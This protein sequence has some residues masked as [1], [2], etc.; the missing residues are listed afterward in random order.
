MK[1][2]LRRF[3]AE[4]IAKYRRP[5]PVP[6][7]V[8]R[9]SLSSRGRA[10]MMSK[11]THATTQKAPGAIP[12]PPHTAGVSATQHSSFSAPAT[13]NPPAF[14]NPFAP[15]NTGSTHTFTAPTPDYTMGAAAPLPIAYT[16]IRP[17][18]HTE[19]HGLTKEFMMDNL[20][21]TLFSRASAN[22]ISAKVWVVEYD[23][24]YQTS[25][26]DTVMKLKS[27][28][29]ALIGEQIPSL[30]II[31]PVAVT[32]PPNRT[33]SR[34][35]GFLV[36]GLTKRAAQEITSENAGIWATE[37][38][39]FLAVP[40][41]PEIT[42]FALTLDRFTLLPNQYRIVQE[43]IADTLI[44]NLNVFSFVESNHDAFPLMDVNTVYEQILQ[45]IEAEPVSLSASPSGKGGKARVVWN[46]LITS[47]TQISSRHAQWIQLL[48]SLKYMHRLGT[49]GLGVPIQSPLSCNRCKI[50]GHVATACPL[51]LLPDWLGPPPITPGQS[52]STTAGPS[53]SG[54]HNNGSGGNYVKQGGSSNRN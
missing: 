48:K 54:S 30:D 20:D 34:P 18:S 33:D 4:L 24:G 7:P 51:P 31:P 45:S 28:I 19:K 26:F 12:S 21:R 50:Q 36:T 49:G 40:F 3:E 14:R 6:S 11:F 44:S 39:Q 38:I 8:R 35:V 37:Q 9:G 46:I 22:A 1:A 29:P 16:P 23:K 2:E 42:K 27:A 47:P 10:R 32:A 17:G 43:T 53:G 5:T 52:Q 41:E 13:S 25:S 15:T